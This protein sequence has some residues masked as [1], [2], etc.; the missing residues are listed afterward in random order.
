MKNG[1][2]SGIVYAPRWC[3]FVRNAGKSAGQLHNTV[4]CQYNHR[5]YTMDVIGWVFLLILSAIGI[6]VLILGGFIFYVY[7]TLYW[8]STIGLIGGVFLWIY[9]NDNFAVIFI[10]LSFALQ[11]WWQQTDWWRNNVPNGGSGNPMSGKKARY[12]KGGKII[13]YEDK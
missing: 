1:H 9:V 12:N 5:E 2:D 13:G 11:Y 4:G 7:I 10:L 8:S 6:A 3:V